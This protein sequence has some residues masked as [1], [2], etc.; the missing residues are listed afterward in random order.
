M[1]TTSPPI[2]IGI[3]GGSGVEMHLSRQMDAA[4]TRTHEPETPFG[5]PSAPVTTGTYTG[6]DGEIDIAMLSRHGRG[7][8][9]HPGQV[10]SR[11][12]IFALKELGCTH[13]IATGAT[14][15]LCEA[16]SPGELV[17]IDQFI[18]RT[19]GRP[20]TFFER[21]AVHVEFAD[22]VCPV[23]RDWLKQ[24]AKRIDWTRVHETGTYLCMEGPSFSTRA[25]SHL[26]RQ[27]GA[28]VVGMT[29]LPEAR[30]A[31]EAE[32][33]YTMIALPTDYDCWRDRD[34][35]QSEPSLIAE[36]IGNLE[37][38]SKAAIA[39]MKAALDDLSVLRE[40]PSPAHEALKLG[41]WTARDLIPPEEVERLRPLWGR[42]FQ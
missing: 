13:L 33:A 34:P 4:R 5:P 15:S 20:R 12:N 11:A 9:Y 1:P 39:L 27:W 16:I 19:D 3:I 32:L 2:R 28:D 26:Y 23:M 40:T 6:G 18:D 38:A 30:L 10:N 17:L 35:G 22:P 41:I 8:V 24:A 14:G 7:H 25:E 36:I 29:A 31:R 42:H 21:A 37:R